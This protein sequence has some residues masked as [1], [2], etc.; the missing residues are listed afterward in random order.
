MAHDALCAGQYGV[1]VSQHHAPSLSGRELIAIDAGYSRDQT[2]RRRRDS[3]FLFGKAAALG[4][5]GQGSVLIETARI[6]QI[7]NVFAGGALALGMPSR[8]HLRAR[9]VLAEGVARHDLGK[10]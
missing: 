8:Y 4:G 1:V 10:V 7:R 3:Q 5:K 2:I 9:H 6:A